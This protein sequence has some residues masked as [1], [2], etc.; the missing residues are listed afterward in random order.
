MEKKRAET[1]DIR[2]QRIRNLFNGETGKAVFIPMDHG[3]Q[4]V[5]EGLEDPVEAFQKFA[6]LSPEALLLNF[7]IVKLVQN[8]LKESTDRPGILMALD[9]NHRWHGWKKPIEETGILGHSL[10][11]DVEQAVRYNV[12]AVK[13]LFDLGLNPKTQLTVFKNVSELVRQCDKYD[14]PIMIEPI[15][16]GPFIPDEKKNDPKIIADGC[17]IAVELGADIIKAAYPDGGPETKEMFA[18]ICE[19]AHV[20]VV[21]LGGAKKNSIRDIFQV[22]RDGIDAGAKGVIFGRNV[23]QRPTDEMEKVVNGLQ[24]IVH[25]NASVDESLAKYKLS[26]EN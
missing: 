4:G 20:P 21:I 1:L 24:D 3:I 14:M 15:D 11:A 9:F 7:G 19:N 17:R 6:G 25:R 26:E 12:D 18:A 5:R 23:W 16:T 22:A 2:E 8:I 10:C 13:V